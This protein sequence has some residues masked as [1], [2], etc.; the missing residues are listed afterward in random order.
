MV[1]VTPGNV[2][3]TLAETT[4]REGRLY[5]AGRVSNRTSQYRQEQKRT[6]VG[7]AGRISA[8]NEPGEIMI[9]LGVVGGVILVALGLAA[10]YDHQAKRR[11][12][13]VGTSTKELPS[14]KV[15]GTFLR[16]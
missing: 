6:R 8:L 10:W 1:T 16:R 7:A 14:G 5:G 11:G 12:W 13:R 4:L 9:F 3:T 15:R 2:K